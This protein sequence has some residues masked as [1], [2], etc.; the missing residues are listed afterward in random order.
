MDSS[1][2]RMVQY[3]SG[4]ANEF[5]A[6]LNRIRT[7]V[8]DHNFTS[9]TANEVILRDFLARRS[10]G[11]YKVGQG[12]ICAPTASDSASK[13]CDIL[14]YDRHNYPL[15]HSE[16]EVVL[17]FPQA[18]KMVVEVKTRLNKNALK[19]AME[20]IRTAKQLN[21]AI[22]GVIFAF[23]SLR[24]ETIIKHLQQYPEQLLMRHTPI[25]ILLLNRGV[26]I[27][28]WPGTELGGGENLYEVR[29]S[30]DKDN[31]IVVAFL[32][33]LFFDVQ[34]QGVWGGAKIMN[35]MQ[36]MLEDRTDKLAEN[37]QVGVVS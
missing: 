30:K 6:R 10:T 31:A 21:Y 18:A 13:Q 23:E 8:P 4:I 5:E 22:N 29:A 2:E 19:D 20:N 35:M 15:V 3:C 33:L 14:L 26:I 32:L 17:V 28:R 25:A 27:H 34:M 24:Q 36:Q 12:F 37:I 16:G 7:F 11:R 1:I 9:G